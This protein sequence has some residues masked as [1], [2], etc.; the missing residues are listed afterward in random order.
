M[1]LTRIL[2]SSF[3]PV[4]QTYCEKD[5]MLYALGLGIGNDP[6]DPGQLKYVYEKNLV[7]L[8]SM[9]NVLASPGLWLSDPIFEVDWVRL[10][11]GE[12]RFVIHSPLPVEGGVTGQFRVI[13]VEDKGPAKGALL[14][15]EKVLSDQV[16]GK[17]LCTVHT[18]GFLRAD[19]GCGSGGEKLSVLEP[20]PEREPDRSVELETQPQSALLYR[21]SA[22]MNPLHADP[23][24]AARAGFERPILHGLCTMGVACYGL[25]RQLCGGDAKRLAAMGMRFINPVYPGD[26]V[27]LDVWN[28]GGNTRFRAY[29]VERELLVLDRGS[30]E[31]SN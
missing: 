5:T 12:Q 22:D 24:V 27:R 1:N 15:F 25:I 13:G 11:H 29:A 8:P 20:V 10:L 26:T 28:R 30:A 23:L 17:K 6:T 7:A 4:Q 31:I 18:T 16:T 2:G 3:A 19:G 21:L 14:F 9:C